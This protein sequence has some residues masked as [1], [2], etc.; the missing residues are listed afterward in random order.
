MFKPVVLS[1]S[2]LKGLLFWFVMKFV[3]NSIDEF[4]SKMTMILLRPL[5]VTW[6]SVGLLLP[7]ALLLLEPLLKMT[8]AFFQKWMIQMERKAIILRKKS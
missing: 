1:S 5:L 8:L 3:D 7:L 4:L 6:V 2:A